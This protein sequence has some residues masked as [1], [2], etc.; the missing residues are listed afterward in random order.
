MHS[1]S[2]MIG[3]NGAAVAAANDERA[4]WRD[5]E[6]GND[7]RRLSVVDDS[8]DFM[9]RDISGEDRQARGGEGK[10]VTSRS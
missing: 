9:I 10:P 7:R 5:T 3:L 6:E 8:R 1:L 2:S 4:G